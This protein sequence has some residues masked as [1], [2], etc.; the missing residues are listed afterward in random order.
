MD[1]SPK[2]TG[3]GGHMAKIQVCGPSA[4]GS[5]PPRPAPGGR[6]PS[7]APIPTWPLR[8]LRPSALP[9]QA[10][11]WDQGLN[12]DGLPSRPLAS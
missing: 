4:R 5:F 11:S 8:C 9:P 2:D 12:Q 10:L 7:L 3:S 1:S 6:R